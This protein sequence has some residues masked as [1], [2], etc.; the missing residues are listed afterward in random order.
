MERHISF[1]VGEFY[2]IYNRGIDKRK[3]FFSTGDWV[4]FQR[5]LFI[6]NNSS[7]QRLQISRIKKLSLSEIGK[8]RDGNKL[9]D[10]AAYAMMPNHFHLVLKEKMENGITEFMRKLMTSYVMY[11][12]KKYD[13]TGGLMCRPFRSKHINSDEYFR[14][15]MSYIHLNPLDQIKPGWKDGGSLDS[16]KEVQKFLENYRYSSYRDY[17]VLNRDESLVLSKEALPIDIS[18]LEA[19]PEMLS[20][21]EDSSAPDSTPV[22]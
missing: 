14:W 13:R 16:K 8:L 9:V 5:L 1:E 7:S 6:C 10:V 12:N 11:M 4:H 20:I 15:L 22:C 19:I 3:I 21:I 18:D 2:H 17:F